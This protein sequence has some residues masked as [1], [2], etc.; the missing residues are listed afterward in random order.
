MSEQRGQQ[1]V[2]QVSDREFTTPFGEVTSL[3]KQARCKHDWQ[4]DGQTLTATR[5]T[6]SKCFKTEFR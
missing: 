4:P 5:W 1:I 3:D 2:E 6:C